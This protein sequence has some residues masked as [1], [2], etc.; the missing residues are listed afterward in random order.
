MSAPQ[1]IEDLLQP[2]LR[3]VFC[4][5]AL[6]RTSYARKAYYAHPRNMF[7]RALY[8]VG[9]TDRPL[10]PEEYR[11]LLGYRIGLTDLCKSEFGNDDELSPRALDRAALLTKIEK[12]RPGVLAFTSQKAGR[13]FCGHR[14][15]LGWQPSSISGTR[16]YVLPS[17]SPMAKWNWAANSRHW[18]VL[19][20][21]VSPSPA[22]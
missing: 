4:G 7:W 21:A 19:A 15:G 14:A 10:K 5:T 13:A 6:G 20:E 16:I 17:T 2:E 3:I 9:L 12:Y 11:N 8:E 1:H 22:D 18:K